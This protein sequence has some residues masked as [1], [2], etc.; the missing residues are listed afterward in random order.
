M[1]KE[2]FD[3]VMNQVNSIFAAW[4]HRNL[5]VIGKIC[6]I[7]T[8]V[9]SL[10]AHKF[11]ALPSPS[12]EFFTK[13]KRKILEFLWDKAP[14]KISYNKLILSYKKLGLK[15]IDLA[16]KDTALKATW[17][18]KLKERDQTE[19]HWMYDALPIKNNLI[20]NVI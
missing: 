11:L 13:Y 7:N 2:N 14:P 12:Q 4:S 8:L 10:F 17:P 15:L 5:M 6:I 20:W 1:I 9:N 19:L 18:I 16:R 3:N